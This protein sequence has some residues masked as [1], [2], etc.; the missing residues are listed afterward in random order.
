MIEDLD[1]EAARRA[2]EAMLKL[3]VAELGRARPTAVAVRL[4]D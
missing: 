4:C 2:M 1:T 3:D